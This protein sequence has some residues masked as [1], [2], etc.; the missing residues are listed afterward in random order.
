M[1]IFNLFCNRKPVA[2]VT[3]EPATPVKTKRDYKSAPG[4]YKP[5]S[6]AMVRLDNIAAAAGVGYNHAKKTALAYG[7]NLRYRKNG[8]VA[9]AADKAKEL[10]AILWD[11]KA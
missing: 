1:G 11:E 5:R 8:K 10:H 6:R 2:P 4:H 3:E 7:F 9:V